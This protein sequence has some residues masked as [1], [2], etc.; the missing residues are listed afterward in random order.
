MGLEESDQQDVLEDR[1]LI[2]TEPGKTMW[3]AESQKWELRRVSIP[4]IRPC[5]D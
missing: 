2:E 3:V 4:G 1:Y 5:A